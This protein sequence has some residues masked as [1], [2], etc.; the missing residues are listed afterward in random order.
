M[1][2]YRIEIGIKIAKCDESEQS[3]PKMHDDGIFGMIISEEDAI[4]IDKCENAILNT[5]YQAMREAASEHFTRIS[6]EKA[7]EQAG[8][9]M[10]INNAHPYHADGE[11]G[12][13]TFTTHT[14][15]KE[16]GTEY[17]TAGELFA[18]L[19]AKEWYKTSGFKEIAIVYG[20]T[21]SSYRKT[22][23]L[24]NRIRYQE[25]GG[26]PLRTLRD[27]TLS[28]GLKIIG[29]IEDKTDNILKVHRFTGNG[30]F[31]GC[32]DDYNAE[33]V[34]LPGDRVREAVEKCQRRFE[35]K[36]M[37][38]EEK[39]SDNPLCYEDPGQTVNISDDDVVVKKQKEK[40]ESRTDGKEKEENK[41]KKKRKYVHNTVVHV[42]K[43]G[44]SYILNG[45]GMTA[46][47]RILIAFLL[48]NDLL[49]YRLQFFTDGHVTLNTLILKCFSW[50][51]N[52]AIILDWFHLVKKCKEKL[53]L[54]MRGRDIRNEI[55][56]GLLPL[57]W[58]GLTDDAAEYLR[59]TDDRL[60]K[61]SKALKEL[62]DYLERNKPYIPSYAVRKELGLRNSSNIGEKMNHLIVSE[63][64]KH[65]GMSWSET[66]SVTLASLT[67]L[68]KNNEYKRWFED[69]DINF[70][71]AA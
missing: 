52:M 69:G 50:H 70:K 57:L 48:H 15:V 37:V 36:G 59:N 63:R 33:P 71:L 28:E 58:Y 65:N 60:V 4:S 45:S 24:I 22:E 44:E 62:I 47:L 55:L 8:E 67:A 35:E 27:G 13:F 29:L 25:E 51:K 16:D 56:R 10:I 7:G 42:E 68:I 61:N 40:R 3:D 11:I 23:K 31:N 30:V 5:G 49:R 1:G 19:K 66:G 54:S 38:A 20:D 39:I 53:S 41:K 18:C 34:K 43:G 17:N 26:T 9:G 32:S 2:N 14:A 64:Q 12:R 6:E 21:E 46:V